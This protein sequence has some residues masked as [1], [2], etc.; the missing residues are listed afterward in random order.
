MTTV[1]WSDAGL[2][3]RR[4]R[5]VRFGFLILP[6][7]NAGSRE[8]RTRVSSALGVDTS[9]K[10]ATAGRKAD[11]GLTDVDR[12]TGQDLDAT[13]KAKAHVQSIDTTARVR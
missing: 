10:P 1:G 4:Q 5:M 12:Q 2:Y 11:T 6:P 8:A 9:V 3:M 13:L 7:R